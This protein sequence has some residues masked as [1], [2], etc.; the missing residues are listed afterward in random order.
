ML[1]SETIRANE[2]LKELSDDQVQA[3]EVLSQNDEDQVIGKKVGE[4]HGEYDR[5]IAE[6]LGVEKPSG[7]KTYAWLKEDILPMAKSTKEVQTNLSK[8]QETI[9]SLEE[10]LKKGTGDE[11]L[12]KKL[13]DQ[14]D[15]V[16]SLRKQQ[17]DLKSDYETKL[18]ETQDGMLGMRV[19]NEF[20]SGLTGLKFKDEKLV[21]TSL[22]SM[23]ISNAKQTILNS[24]RPDFVKADGSDTEQL[25][26][27]DEKGEIARNPENA[28]KPYTAKELLL[29][30]ATMKDI[31]DAKKVQGGAGGSGDGGSRN[32]DAE[33]IDI[34]SAKTQVEANALIVKKLAADGVARGSAEFNEK[35]TQLRKDNGVDKL[36]MR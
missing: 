1:K 12:K 35:L 6:V 23:V 34:S 33:I 25:I 28:L 30:E 20:D 15:L 11:S 29:K 26:F 9:T 16:V 2:V 8:A 18:K 17:D 21:S 7:K 10:Q 19:N 13:E 36:E 4:I 27:R 3:I 31:L 24:Y 14:E 32:E 5:D 22:R